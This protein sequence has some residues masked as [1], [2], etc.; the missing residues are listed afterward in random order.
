MSRWRI[1]VCAVTSY[2]RVGRRTHQNPPNPPRAAPD[3]PMSR[4]PRRTRR[5]AGGNAEEPP[6]HPSFWRLQH[7]D[8]AAGPSGVRN[9]RGGRSCAAA[10]W[11]CWAGWRRTAPSTPADARR[12]ADLPR[13][14]PRRR[15]GPA[16]PRA[17][18]PPARGHRRDADGAEAGR[19]P[20]G[21]WRRWTR[22]GGLDS[23]A[24]S[25]VWHV[26]GCGCSI[27]EWAA[28]RGWGGRP[29]GHAQAQGILVAALG[30]LAAHFRLR[31][32]GGAAQD[33]PA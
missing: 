20:Q 23:A 21:R 15:A 29:V 28:R 24:G 33:R 11:T 1:L 30:V 18:G 3:G 27:R 12:R 13:P 14:V 5:V 7:G 22:S 4:S 10:R 6:Q 32:P 16:A 25:C 26:V 2:G 8:V 31:A 19:P 17:A 9:R